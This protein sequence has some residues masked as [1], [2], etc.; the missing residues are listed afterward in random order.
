MNILKLKYFFK[1]KWIFLLTSL[2]L[3]TFA[4]AQDIAPQ[5]TKSDLK[6]DSLIALGDKQLNEA[7]MD[8]ALKAYS[9]ALNLKPAESYPATQ[10]QFIQEQLDYLQ[11]QNS[12][13]KVSNNIPVTSSFQKLIETADSAVSEKRYRAAQQAYAEALTIDP[14]NKYAL[15][16][17][18]IATHQ[19][20]LQT[21][22]KDSTSFLPPTEELRN[23]MNSKF[24]WQKESIPYSAEELKMNFPGIDFY[25]APAA[26]QFNTTSVLNKDHSRI[27]NEL[28]VSN[29]KMAFSSTD[30]DIHL[31]NTDISFYDSLVY[32]K[33]ILQNDSPKDFLTGVML[34]TWQRPNKEP[35]KLYPLYLYPEQFP[36]VKPG[37]QTVLIYVCKPYVVSIY[38]YVNFDL[39]DRLDKIHLQV[40]IP[41]SGWNNSD[42]YKYFIKTV[43]DRD[44]IL[45][46]Q[47]D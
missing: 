16:R 2:I 7:S 41:G 4:G 26:Q 39:T 47:P 27:L 1:I 46:N 13:E 36:I 12:R 33:M 23:I 3:V 17:L 11:T 15:Q 40:K 28:I 25:H 18:K 6:Y 31:I 45:L 43:D 37:N 20:A 8:A 44:N 14:E 5:K 19:L 32:V 38:D 30:Q 9:K 21:T 35:I 10:I 42:Y 29:P 24:I 22:I 34:L